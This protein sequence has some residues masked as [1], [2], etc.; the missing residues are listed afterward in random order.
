[1]FDRWRMAKDM[2]KLK[3]ALEAH[4]RGLGDSNVDTRLDSAAVIQQILG[5]YFL[6][7]EEAYAIVPTIAHCLGDNDDAR[8]RG[9]ACVLLATIDLQ[10]RTTSSS[11]VRNAVRLA[12][13]QVRDLLEDEDERVR[14]AAKMVLDKTDG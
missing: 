11:G 9:A 5:L 2:R 7:S 4:V 13:P 14:D 6:S 10:G 8:V 12:L 3:Q 1:V